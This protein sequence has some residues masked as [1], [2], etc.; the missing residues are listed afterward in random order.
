MESQNTKKFENILAIERIFKNEIKYDEADK[1]KYFITFPYPYMNGKLHLGHL[2]S[3]TKAEFMARFK[4]TTG[5]DVFFPFSFHGSGMPILAVANKLVDQDK[6][7]IELMSSIGINDIEPF[8]NPY[9]WLEYFSPL[10]KEHLQMFHSYNNWN[11]SFITTEYNSFYDSFVKW[12]FEKL[13]NFIS[14]GKKETI[15]CTKTEQPCLDHDRKSGEGVIPAKVEM[16]MVQIGDLYFCARVKK[17]EVNQKKID[18]S[19]SSDVLKIS[20]K[21][22]YFKVA[23]QGK[24]CIIDSW[25]LENMKYQEFNF[26]VLEQF[27]VEQL[28]STESVE[29]SLSD[30]D[31]PP[32]IM[33]STEESTLPCDFLYYEPENEVLSRSGSKCVVALF[34][35]WFLNYDDAEWKEK[36]K[37]CI[38]KMNIHSGT[39]QGLLEGVDWLDKWGFSRTFGLGTKY[40]EFLIDSLSDSTI[41]MSL[42]TV[43]NEIFGDI[44]GRKNKINLEDMSHLAWDYIF[45]F[46][47]VNPYHDERAVVLERARKYFIRYYP[48]DLRVS[49]KDLIKNHL[50]F[51]IFNHVAIFP[52][53]Y[54]PRR[55]FTNGHLTL[56]GAKM[57]KSEG[58]FLTAEDSIKLY[59]AS[60][61]RLVLADAGD[62]N[63]DANFSEATAQSYLL[64]IH[65]FIEFVDFHCKIDGVSF[66]EM[67]EKNL[68]DINEFAKSMNEKE[69]K[70]NFADILLFDGVSCL[71]TESKTAYEEMSY[72]NVVKY[73]LHEFKSLLELCIS[74][75]CSHSA[76]LYAIKANLIVLYP[77]IPAISEYF[78]EKYF[79][80][81]IDWPEVSIKADSLYHGLEWYKKFS[82]NLLNKF[83]KSKKNNIKL[84]IGTEKPEWKSEIEKIDSNDIEKLQECFKKFNISQKKAMSYVK[85]RVEYHFDESTFINGMKEHLNS[86]L[87]TTIEIME[88]CQR[89]EPYEPDF[90]F[91]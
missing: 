88:N 84:F 52:E 17:S 57:S 35:Q 28:K 38:S 55:I 16:K 32:T 19:K 3:F 29:L 71:A 50:L 31:F 70:N 82:K 48:V 39:R 74:L 27:Q 85:D 34:S 56:N 15:Y 77:I 83:K 33:I 54:W 78:L 79:D 47:D 22:Q 64:K 8:K 13:E 23:F 60:A 62:F 72:R 69:A 80:K 26:E 5:Y 49:G 30:A 10:A 65:A 44:Y 40:K 43:R 20:K 81:S 24:T 90:E 2:F 51:Y 45:E 42:Y 87:G 41:Y 11:H 18:S 61:S 76:I 75:N 66:T 91:F 46:T 6:K 89:G 21:L 12:Q 53:K 63:D 7:Q 37:L 36:V 1:P 67:K 68:S 86:K 58:N 14:Y 4:L 25:A 73:G 9:Y 59:G